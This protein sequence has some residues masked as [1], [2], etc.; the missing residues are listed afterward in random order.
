MSAYFLGILVMVA[1]LVAFLTTFVLSWW[2][3]SNRAFWLTRLTYDDV[4]TQK[5]ARL[6][7]LL[8]W[9]LAV[10]GSL[11]VSVNDPKLPH[12]FMWILLQT[13]FNMVITWLIAK[14][15]LAV[16]ILVNWIKNW[17][18]EGK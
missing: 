13:C 4:D 2:Y 14:V 7:W 16:A 11:I 1:A 10:V 12:T 8:A 15:I 5:S 6:F 9:L 17:I 3:T 18:Y